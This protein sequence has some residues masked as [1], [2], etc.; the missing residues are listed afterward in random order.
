VTHIL[1]AALCLPWSMPFTVA[2]AFAIGVALGAL[3]CAG[4]CT[5]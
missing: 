2:C 1:I 5:V 4:G 3:M